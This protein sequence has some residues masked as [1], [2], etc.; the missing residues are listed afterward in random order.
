MLLVLFENLNPKA[1]DKFFITIM[2][3]EIA[4]KINRP[5][6]YKIVKALHTDDWDAINYHD[7]MCSKY[8]ISS[9]GTYDEVDE[10]F[11]Y[12]KDVIK[13]SSGELARFK[14]EMALEL[15]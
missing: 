6:E 3:N 8:G 14:L 11:E 7:H 1:E 15:A 12:L 13:D 2:E 10:C 5:E 9:V 4:E